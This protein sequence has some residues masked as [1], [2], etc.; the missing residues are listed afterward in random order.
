MLSAGEHLAND[1]SKIGIF[2]KRVY[3]WGYFP[4]YPDIDT[5]QRTVIDTVRILWTGR[6]LDWK[7]PD[8][9]VGLAEKALT[10]RARFPYH[11]DWR[12]RDDG[13]YK[14]TY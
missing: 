4:K 10:G 12:W 13:G 14:K 11:N 3:K 9:M 6:F 2:K 1:L 7:R 8:M 5:P